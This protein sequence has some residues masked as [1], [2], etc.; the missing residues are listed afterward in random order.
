[1]VDPFS[2]E[3]LEPL[4]A[5][6]RRR[7]RGLTRR[8]RRAPQFHDSF[9]YYGASFTPTPLRRSSRRAAATTC[10]AELPALVGDGDPRHGRARPV[11]LP[12]DAR[13]PAPRLRAPLDRVGARAGQPLAQPG[14]RRARQPARP[15]RRR[16]HPRDR[17]VPAG[18]TRRMMP[19]LK[20]AS[21]AAHV[22][23]RRARLGR[24]VHLARR[25]LQDSALAREAG[26]RLAVPLGRQP[27]RLPR[28]PVLARRGSRGRAGSS[29][30]RSTSA[31]KAAC[32]AT[33]RRSTAL[34]D[35]RP[36]RSCRR[37]SPTT[38]SSSTTRPHDVWYDPPAPA[39][40]RR[41][42]AVEPGSAGLRGAGLRLWQR[43]YSWDAVSGRPARRRP[44]RG[45]AAPARR[46]LLPRARASARRG[47][48][49]PRPRAALAALARKARRR[50]ARGRPSRGRAGLR[51][52]RGAARRSSAR[53]SRRSMRA[54]GRG[55]V[56]PRT[57]RGACSSATTPSC[58][59]RQPPARDDDRRGPPARAPAA[60][61]RP[62]TTSS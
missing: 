21:S 57:P 8:E 4:P 46:R 31:R 15:L 30:P 28:H 50:D 35:A 11:R 54:A 6:L 17:G 60:R 45:R 19:R 38:T 44:R 51:R 52:A 47:S 49:R 12:R 48:C 25:A 27:P 5:P 34:P 36:V 55:V 24:G 39:Q 16:R 20:L 62:A 13:R 41:P 59:L 29:T 18:R 3:S 53:R 40:P 10:A 14:A 9:E 43:G 26:G 32:G 42:R 7:L 22:S 56:A 37:A 58:W 61:G 23:G 33:C 1:M 2:A